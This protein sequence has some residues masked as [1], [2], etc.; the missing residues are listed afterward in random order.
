MKAKTKFKK[1]FYK[2]PEIA[3]QELVYDFV[4]QPMNLSACWLE[5]KYETE[6][7]KKILKNLGYEDDS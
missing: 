2:L 6:L 5:I 1:M 3:R 7:G 4:N